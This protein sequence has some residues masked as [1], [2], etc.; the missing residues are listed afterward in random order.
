[1]E[2]GFKEI[3]EKEFDC[4]ITDVDFVIKNEGNLQVL[5]KCMN[6]AFSLHGV[7]SSL[8]RQDDMEHRVEEITKQMSDAEV[9]R[10]QIEI[11]QKGYTHGWIEGRIPKKN[12]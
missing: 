12:W 5:L 8:P 3:I 4:L 10:Q 2:Q 9:H 11:W 7:I 6:Q 1:M